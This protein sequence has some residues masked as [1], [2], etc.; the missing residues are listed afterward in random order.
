M[1]VDEIGGVNPVDHVRRHAVAHDADGDVVTHFK[2]QVGGIHAVVGADRADLLTAFHHLADLHQHRVEVRVEG[3]DIFHLTT[4]LVPISMAREYQLAPTGAHIVGKGHNAVG[5]R[6][7]RIAK[8]AVAA[9]TAIPVLAKM[10][11]CAQTQAA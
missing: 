6:V 3:V 1:A 9:A 2:M 5:D 4:F 11:R 7:N 8:I 10:L